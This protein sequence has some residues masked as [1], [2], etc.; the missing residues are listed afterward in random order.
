MATYVFSDVHGHVA[1]LRRALERVSPGESDEFYCL[2]DMIDRGPEPLAVVRACLEL[3]NCTILKG[4]H[5]ALMLDYFDHP[6]DPLAM[7]NWGQNGAA[8]T[9]RDL[10]ELDTERL[11]AFLGWARALPL[12]AATTVGKR[13]YIMAHA[14]IRASRAPLE[15]LAGVDA[16]ADAIA[17]FMDGQSEEDLLWIRD[18][19]WGEPTGL[20]TS[21]GEGSVVIAGHTPTLYLRG[22][23]LLDRSPL[24]RIGRCRM[25]RVG[26]TKKTGG[27]PDKW[28]ID[29]G[30]A[31]G[32]GC[33]QVLVL[34]LD[35][36]CEFME[37]VREGE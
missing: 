32:A 8:V 21:D 17:K 3:P 37:P 25:V 18:E 23:D 22:F 2:G 30:A 5:E 13:S 4:N 24:D 33:G 14:G 36:G 29:C 9:I 20:L 28:D 35:D 1:P 15:G 34:R 10:Q 31:G 27:V 19:F 11:M 7:T 6:N 16:D 12:W 26:A